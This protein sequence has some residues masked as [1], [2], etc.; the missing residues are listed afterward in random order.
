MKL[1]GFRLQVVVFSFLF[2]LFPV[3]CNLSTTYAITDPLSV[4]N[5]KFGIHIISGSDAEIASASALVNSENGD[6]GYLTLVIQDSDQDVI[7]WQK[8]FDKLREK[9]LI[10]IVRLA[11]HPI[12]DTWAT[13]D[14]DAADKWANFLGSLTWPT[15]N[16]YIVVYNEP[17]HAKEWGG[18]VDAKAYARV[19]NQTIDALKNKN[20]D[21]FM[22]NAGLD[23]STPQEPPNYVEELTFLTQ[24]NEEVPGIFEKLDGWDSHS[25]PNPGFIGSPDGVGRGTVKTWAWEE[26]ALKDLGV[27][28]SLPI[29]ITET[30]WKHAEGL[31]YNPNFPTGVQTGD[32]YRQAFQG[33]WNDPKIVAVTPFLLNY[34]NP[35]FD[36]FQLQNSDS[37]KAIAELTKAVGDPVQDQAGL[38][39]GSKINPTLIVGQSYHIRLKVKNIGQSIWGEK[40]PIRLIP[41]KGRELG[42]DM[43]N[44]PADVKVLP[45]QEYTFEFDL[46][47]PKSGFYTVA[48]NMYQGT[49]VF[50]NTSV[51]FS[52]EA[53]S[54]IMQFA[55]SH[56]PEIFHPLVQK[57]DQNLK[58]TGF[59][60]FNHS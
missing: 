59:V 5:N 44:I 51:Q 35:P 25:Y 6:W 14:S 41:T 18:T 22:L 58:L 28:K 15:K 9:H 33:A 2:F 46:K 7:R 38:F 56:L 1:L 12:G 57:L 32:Y 52:V 39:I 4:P 43:V 19:L 11:T 13:P 53:G 45:G 27:Q 60:L 29:F 54:P 23:A 36:H 3:T 31:N 17:N 37:F 34:P 16:R 40:E 20:A 21:F 24:M 8:F 49:D 10:P 55:K 47:A 26:T 30:G 48:L 50:Q 42:I